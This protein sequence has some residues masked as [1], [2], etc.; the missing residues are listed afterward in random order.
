[1]VGKNNVNYKTFLKIIFKYLFIIRK[2]VK[3]DKISLLGRK[4]NIVIN[5]ILKKYKHQLKKKI[6]LCISGKF[7]Q[8]N[9]I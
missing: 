9:V 5:N 1:M 8:P 4:S 6:F 3:Y 2:D 7:K